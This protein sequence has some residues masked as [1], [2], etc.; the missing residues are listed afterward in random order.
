MGWLAGTGMMTEDGQAREWWRRQIMGERWS[1]WLKSPERRR[2]VKNERN[3]QENKADEDRCLQ[4]KTGVT[5]TNKPPNLLPLIL[6]TPL[7][8]VRQEEALHAELHNPSFPQWQI[9]ASL[10]SSSSLAALAPALSHTLI[11]H[12][13]SSDK[14]VFP[15]LLGTCCGVNGGPLVLLGTKHNSNHGNLL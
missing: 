6:T 3:L 12:S 8:L 4:K 9:P 1:G 10:H 11:T 13:G 2:S 15:H 7:S 14:A 5:F